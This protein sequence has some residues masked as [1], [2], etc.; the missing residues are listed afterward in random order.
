MVRPV[1]A[2]PVFGGNAVGCFGDLVE[3]GHSVM[4]SIPQIRGVHGAQRA[5]ALL[6]AACV[7]A[8]ALEVFAQ[9][10]G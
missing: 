4:Q 10:P 7:D 2:T 6:E 5:L 9:H 8:F 1:Q 3:S